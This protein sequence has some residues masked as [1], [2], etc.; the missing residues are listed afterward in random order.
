MVR[1]QPAANLEE[2]LTIA[3]GEFVEDG[4]PCGVRQGPEYIVADDVSIGKQSLACQGALAPLWFGSPSPIS[5]SLGS[6]SVEDVCEEAPRFGCGGCEFV[7]A[8]D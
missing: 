2:R 5:W 8:D 4:P 6:G 7:V 1:H 3:L